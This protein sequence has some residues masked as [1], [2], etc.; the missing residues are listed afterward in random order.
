M[1]NKKISKEFRLRKIMKQET[2]SWVFGLS[3][4]QPHKSFN[5]L[6][7]LLVTMIM[8]ILLSM[9]YI[10]LL[11]SQVHILKKLSYCL[12]SVLFCGFNLWATDK[13]MFKVVQCSRNPNRITIALF[14]YLVCYIIATSLIFNFFH[15]VKT[16]SYLND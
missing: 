3:G 7:L 11:M 1:S 12:M 15:F 13:Y 10:D 6:N 16:K 14:H 2:I 5:Q 9:V 8:C 4:S